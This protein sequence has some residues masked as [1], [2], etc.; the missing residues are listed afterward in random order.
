VNYFVN[1]SL[2]H[3]QHSAITYIF[4]VLYVK[5]ISVSLYLSTIILTC[6]NV[7]QQILA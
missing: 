2:V 3:I 5:S 4:T 6:A 1:Y 7:I